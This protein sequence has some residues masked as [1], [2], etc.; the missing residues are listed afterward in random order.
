MVN[1]GGS[2]YTPSYL[3]RGEDDPKDYQDLILLH[4][5]SLDIDNSITYI[6]KHFTPPVAKFFPDFE[7]KI[8]EL[9]Q[10]AKK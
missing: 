4:P 5:T 3:S 1:G 8:N 9:K 6:R 7:D 2:I 10:L